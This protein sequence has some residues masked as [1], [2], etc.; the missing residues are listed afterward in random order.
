M[1]GINGFNFVDKHRAEVMN[2]AIKHRGPD[3]EGVFADENVTLG[4][5][6]LAIID[7]SKAGHQP[8]VYEHNGKSS[9]IVFNGE[10]YNFETIR[11]D[12]ESKGYTFNSRTDTEVILASYLEWGFD[13]V[14]HFNG[15]WAFVIFDRSKI[16]LFCS[17]DRLGVKPF[18][19][20]LDQGKFIFSSELKGILTHDNLSLNRKENINV[21]ALNL[22]FTLGFIPSPYTIY[23]NVYKLE[24]RQNLVFD[25]KTKK[26]EKWYYYKIPKYEPEYNSKKLIE[27]GRELLKNAVRLRMI[28]DVPIGAFLS[29]GLDSTTTV[30]TMSEFTNVKNLHTFSIG[31]EGKYDETPFINIA[32]GYFHS[33]HHHSYFVQDDFEKLIDT[34]AFIF[35]E[36]LADYSAFP[37][38]TL[39]KMAREHVTVALSGDGG[40][41]MFG[42]Y[43]VYLIGYRMQMIRKIPRSLRVLLSKIPANENLN[44]YVSLYLLKKGFQVSLYDPTLFFANALE[45]DLFLPNIYKEWT[46][47]K[48]KISME[49]GADN[50]ADVLRLYD[51]LFNTLPDNYLE[52]VDRASMAYALEVR[53]PFLDYRFAEFS[54]RIPTELQVDLF[55]SKKLLKEITKGIVPDEI[56]HRGK[57]GFDPPLQDWI[58]DERYATYLKQ[59]ADRLNEIDPELSKFFNEKVLR[60]KNKLYGRYKIRLFLFGVWFERWINK[61]DLELPA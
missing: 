48:L 37:T 14:N 13:C 27:E 58:L 22:Y 8:M 7:L 28:A 61:R 47:D 45:T 51:M 29:G 4:H 55:K 2:K 20:F 32:K 36:P 43:P 16:I 34:Y 11:K 38:L 41:E 25:L 21:D 1:C 57:R 59:S 46:K 18:H 33:K 24:A 5:V 42:G 26:T 6:R 35:D 60:K 31:F 49:S 44:G 56:R 10:I 53:S 54:Q 39:S 12:L 15:M 50:F 3:D 30:G 9:I 52:K 17:R 19:Y 40:D 23:N